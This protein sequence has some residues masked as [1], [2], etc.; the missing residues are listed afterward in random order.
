V[1][2]EA[3]EDV[4]VDGIWIPKG[5]VIQLS[6]AVI[7]LHPNVWGE[8]ST[9]FDPNRWENHKGP[10]ANAYALQTFHNG[11]RMCIGKQLA[12]MEMKAIVVELLTRFRIENIVG[13]IEV[14]KPTL[15]LRPKT[16]LSVRLTDNS[17][18]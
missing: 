15:T 1:P 18:L 9:E 7:N 12:V 4:E 2:R 6:P 14:A 17:L 11:P 13:E 3:V 8:R 5:T 10:A 16:R